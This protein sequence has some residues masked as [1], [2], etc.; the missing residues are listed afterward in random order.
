MKLLES[1][2][3]FLTFKF[4]FKRFIYMKL[5]N[6]LYLIKFNEYLFIFNDFL[7]INNKI[8]LL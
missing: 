2:I 8:I 5:F 6:L 3:L 7:V 1:F 4:K